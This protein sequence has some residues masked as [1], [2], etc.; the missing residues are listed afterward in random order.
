VTALFSPQG[1][2]LYGPIEM[3]EIVKQSL[4]AHGFE[5]EQTEDMVFC[6]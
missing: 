2:K 1:V 6:V 3:I 5:I 4:E